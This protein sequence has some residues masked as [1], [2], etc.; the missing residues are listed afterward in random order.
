MLVKKW[1]C[2]VC[3]ELFDYDKKPSSC[4]VCGVGQELFEL[5]EVEV[6]E[7]SIEKEVD[8]LII[9]G[10]VAAVNVADAIST[11]NKKARI[12]IISKEKYLP[13]Y[14]TRLTEI[15]DNDIPMERMLIKKESW[16]D[17]RNIKLLLEEEVIS[18][19][20]YEKF[21]ELASGKR[22]KY[23]SLVVASGAR[24]FVPPFENK[25]LKNVR[26][27]REMA[28][29]Y[30]IID[31]AK[32]SKKVVV[33]GGGVLGLEAAWGFKNLGLDVTILEVMPR[34]LP[35]QLDEKGSELLE[36][37]IK[38]SG[39]NIMTG[40]EIKG[41]AG[42]ESVEKVILKNGVELDT[43]LVIISAGI[44]PNKEFML[45]TKIAV[46][47]G[48]IVNEKMETSI[49]DI[50]ACGDIAEYN[51]KVIGLWQVAMEQGKIVGANIC[52]EEKIY[53][54]QIQP[55]SFEGMNTQL[56]SIGNITD[57]GET[58]VDYNA[59]KNI[60]RKFF[61]KNEI[62]VGALLIGDTGKSVALIKGV[63]EGVKK[64]QVLAKLY[65]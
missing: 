29:T 57:L 44:S 30:D 64:I 62:L 48:V 58:V 18:V 42:S 50:Y 2:T 4:P 38:T 6:S 22:L 56:L 19:A 36:K 54:E 33:I 5:V 45:S 14:R 51:G 34:V 39:V 35:R 46:N 59:E 21:V 13:Y 9:G 65:N 52:G 43:D 31:I 26:V 7:N 47:R 20:T 10:G 41:F 25:D 8:I 28:E 12:T 16:Y 63:R 37:L 27:I 53:S 15:I 23:D 49:K 24:C 55:L 61:F 3:D 17:E 60:Y 40:V 1:R 11:R 32:K